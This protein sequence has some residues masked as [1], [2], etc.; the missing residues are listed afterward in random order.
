MNTKSVTP[1]SIPN[2]DIASRARQI[3]E[4]GGCLSGHELD[5]WLQAERELK[6]E[7]D[8]LKAQSSSGSGRKA[9]RSLGI[10]KTGLLGEPRIA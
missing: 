1:A 4:Q 6:Q 2:Q 7:I 3:W 8:D 9:K 5:H 10:A